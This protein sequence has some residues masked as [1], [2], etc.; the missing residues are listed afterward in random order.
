M[1]SN[2]TTATFSVSSSSA[3]RHTTSS[4]SVDHTNRTTGSRSAAAR[5]LN[6]L[7]S[8]SRPDV[9]G[10]QQNTN[11]PSNQARTGYVEKR[12][13]QLPPSGRG[14]TG[15]SAE[16]PMEP[17]YEGDETFCC[18][19]Q[20]QL[21]AFKFKD[22]KGVT[23]WKDAAGKFCKP[24]DSNEWLDHGGWGKAIWTAKRLSLIHI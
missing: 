22:S 23:R 8:S 18:N 15:I 21:I 16:N 20:G 1:S 7:R 10:A 14:S 12:D 19:R 2:Q 6:R 5:G 4:S 13:R 24:P 17:E 11:P 3:G 9:G